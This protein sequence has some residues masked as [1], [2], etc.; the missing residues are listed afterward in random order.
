M[1]RT[2]NE[3]ELSLLPPLRMWPDVL[4]LASSCDNDR[5]DCSSRKSVTRR[6]A[7]SRLN[8]CKSKVGLSLE[9]HAAGCLTLVPLLLLTVCQCCCFPFADEDDVAAMTRTT[10]QYLL[11][12]VVVIGNMTLKRLVGYKSLFLLSQFT[13]SMKRT[14]VQ[15]QFQI[16]WC[17]FRALS[18]ALPQYNRI[19]GRGTS[20][21]VV[22]R[23]LLLNCLHGLYAV[24]TR[25]NYRSTPVYYLYSTSTCYSTSL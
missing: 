7:S 13:V 18:S 23:I 25:Q 8:P 4:L 1:T 15:T 24:D 5:D 3:G 16:I 9:E 2:Q 11:Y 19:T 6:M 17:T 20:S 14:R 12:V 22:V 10:T 21:E